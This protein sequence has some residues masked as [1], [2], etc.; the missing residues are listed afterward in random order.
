MT[1]NITNLIILS[2]IK[3][4]DFLL[5]KCVFEKNIVPTIIAFFNDKAS[6]FAEGSSENYSG[7]FIDFTIIKK[8]MKITQI[9]HLNSINY[10]II[11]NRNV[12]LIYKSCLGNL[13][14][15]MEFIFHSYEIP[16]EYLQNFQL[17]FSRKFQKKLSDIERFSRK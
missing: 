16:G 14:M 10:V 11:S 6:S 15:I 5:I 17:K 8:S 1:L 13:H 12:S 3:L 4:N 7:I 2:L 9:F